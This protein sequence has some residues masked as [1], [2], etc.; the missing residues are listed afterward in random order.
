ML[1][2]NSETQFRVLFVWSC[3]SF[4]DTLHKNLTLSK[5]QK[6]MNKLSWE[7]HIM[8]DQLNIASASNNVIEMSLSEFLWESV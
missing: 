7:Q 3:P 5:D 2:A 6:T 4:I 8:N 1:H